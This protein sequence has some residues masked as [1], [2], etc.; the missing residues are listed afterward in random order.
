MGKVGK[1]DSQPVEGDWGWGWGRRD[2]CRNKRSRSKASFIP[3]LLNVIFI[4]FKMFSFF[5]QLKKE[6]N[7]AL[8]HSD[9]Q[10]LH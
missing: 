4:I 10:C 2:C 7:C 9:E 1:G 6:K 5:F 3:K 8:E